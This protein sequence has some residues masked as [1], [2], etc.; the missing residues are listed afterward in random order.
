MLWWC[1]DHTY[2]CNFTIFPDG[3]T[4]DYRSDITGYPDSVNIR[5]QQLNTRVADIK[6]ILDQLMADGE[7]NNIID[8]EKVGVLGHSYGGATAIQTAYEDDRFKAVLTL[9]SWMNPL[10]EHIIQ[11]GINQ[12]F[13]YLGRPDW[14]DSDYPTSPARLE[15]FLENANRRK[16]SLYFAGSPSFGF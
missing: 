7:L 2:D 12:P 10:P 15:Q 13:L 3:H 16:I 6:F 4:A 9:D 8:F 11:Q 5:R 14:E 1:P